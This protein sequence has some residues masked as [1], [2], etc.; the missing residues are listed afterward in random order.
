MKCIEEG[1]GR[2]SLFELFNVR[3][4]GEAIRYVSFTGPFLGEPSKAALIRNRLP[5]VQ[6]MSS[7]IVEHLT[8][9][10]GAALVT[11]SGLALLL[12]NFTLNRSVKVTGFFIGVFMIGAAVAIQRVIARR[13]MVLT[14]LMRRLEQFTGRP[15]FGKRAESVQRMEESI[16]GFYINRSSTFFLVLMLEL[17]AHFINIVEVYLILRFIGVE[18]TLL[19]AFI[20][21]AMTKVVNFTFFFV[22]GQVG[23]FEGSS[24]LML[25]V[26][27]PGAAAGVKLALMEKIRN[28]AWTAY[29]LVILA[30]AF[31]KA[32]PTPPDKADA[33]REEA[34]A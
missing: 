34:A 29:G 13:R 2:I 6:G 23:V 11:M 33:Q 30:L 10:L 27:G 19:S 25:E 3:L 15:W 21:E 16:H 24:A 17:T 12:S 26:L 8:Y 7:L 28:L 9:S 18:A 14:H 22:P 1:H 20:V 31:R 32:S 4:A 5:L